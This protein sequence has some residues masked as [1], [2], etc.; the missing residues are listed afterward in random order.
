M[1]LLPIPNN[2]RLNQGNFWRTTQMQTFYFDPALILLL[3]ATICDSR[4]L[5]IADIT[6]YA[7]Q[8]QQNKRKEKN[9]GKYASL[10]FQFEGCNIEN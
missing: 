8:Q 1:S 3:G 6:L 5:F 4:V 10:G 7:R 2:K 9:L